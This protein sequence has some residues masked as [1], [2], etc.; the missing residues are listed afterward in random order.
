MTD[1][2][3]PPVRAVVYVRASLPH[4]AAGH[5]ITRQS[6]AVADHARR[7][8]LTVA[9]VFADGGTRS[10]AGTTARD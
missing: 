3:A 9:A 7:G 6:A 4:P 10:T 5:P 1:R 8:G 2:P